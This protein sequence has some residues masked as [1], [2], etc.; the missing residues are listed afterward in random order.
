MNIKLFSKNNCMQCMM[1]KKL[2]ND[3]NVI[4]EE[5]N[6]DKNPGAAE[7]LREQGLRTVPVVFANGDIIIGFRPDKLKSLAGQCSLDFSKTACSR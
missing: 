2:L 7:E 1:A 6:L 4:F 3:N 5:I